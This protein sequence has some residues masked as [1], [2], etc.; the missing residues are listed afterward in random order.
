MVIEGKIQFVAPKTTT[1][2][3]RESILDKKIIFQVVKLQDIVFI[4][5]DDSD[6]VQ[7]SHLE[8]AMNSRFADHPL[9]T[10]LLG[11]T[12]ENP[13]SQLASR[14]AKKSKMTVYLSFNVDDTK[15][16]SSLVEKRL[17]QEMNQ[18]PEKF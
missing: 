9:S 16:L 10:T 2:T 7:L 17:I 3:F 5:I 15:F 8:M 12:A 4:Y 18:Y 6:Q 14:I 11:A 1:H 13:G